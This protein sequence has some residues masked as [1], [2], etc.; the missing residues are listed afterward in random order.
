L[1]A[2]ASQSVTA[3]SATS[4]KGRR[5]RRNARRRSV[6]SQDL[7]RHADDVVEPWADARKI[8]PH[9]D[10]DVRCEQDPV[11]FRAFLPTADRQVIDSDH[12]NSPLCEQPGR[13]QVKVCV[14]RDESI[15]I[16]AAGIVGAF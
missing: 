1:R 12:P 3:W 5:R 14:V 8:E 2:A 15:L 10:H 6:A 7:E 11:D 4:G 16:P 13:A 9:D